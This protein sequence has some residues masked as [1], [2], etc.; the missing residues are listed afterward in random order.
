[1]IFNLSYP[2]IRILIIWYGSRNKDQNVISFSLELLLGN[3]IF[4]LQIKEFRQFLQG[5]IFSLLLEVRFI[6]DINVTALLL[7]GKFL[8]SF[9]SI[10]T[11]RASG[12]IKN[13]VYTFSSLTSEK[14]QRLLD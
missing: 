6:L 1:M 12:L 11:T 13:K 7:L 5:H 4:I 8:S 9:I 10:Y 14:A 3:H 2:N